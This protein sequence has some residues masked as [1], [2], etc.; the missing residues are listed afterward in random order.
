MAADDL[1]VAIDLGGTKVLAALA[2]EQ[3]NTLARHWELTEQSEAGLA[4]Q[5]RR[6]VHA[7]LEQG[8]ADKERIRGIG[9][10]SPGPLDPDTGVIFDTPNIAIHDFPLKAILEEEF[11]APVRVNNDVNV[12]TLGEAW[13]GAGSGYHSVLGIFPGTGIGGGLVVEGKIFVGDSKNALE[14]GHMIVERNGPR[15]NCGNYGCLEAFAS[16]THIGRQLRE[17]VEGGRPSLISELAQGEDLERVHPGLLAE[18][19]ERG[20][21]VVT[22]VLENAACALGIGSINLVHLFGPAVMVYG[23]GL[24]QVLGDFFMPRI[25]KMVFSRCLK[26]TYE[27]TTLRR[28][29]LGDDAVLVGAVA[30][31]LG[32]G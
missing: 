22:E 2:D 32:L 20:D 16:R 15:C 11:R 7:V 4:A 31:A 28:A 25:E 23:G 27:H 18:A 12:G 6:V 19:L 17:I 9:V 5:L 24:I 26:G 14:I 1:F 21:E 29:A 30:L 13:R 10:G 8:G 3:A